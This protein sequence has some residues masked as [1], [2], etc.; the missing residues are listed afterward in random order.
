MSLGRARDMDEP[1][2]LYLMLTDRDDIVV[3]GV[4]LAVAAVA[5]VVMA[6][7]S[8]LGALSW[9]HAATIIL[10]ASLAILVASAAVVYQSDDYHGDHAPV[11]GFIFWTI[12]RALLPLPTWLVLGTLAAVTLKIKSS[13]RLRANESPT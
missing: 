13:R 1:S 3:D 7:A 4:S 2:V 8:T 11:G 6:R 5:I 10:A 12:L 9:S